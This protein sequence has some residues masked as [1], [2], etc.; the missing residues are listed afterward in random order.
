MRQALH[1]AAA[2]KHGDLSDY[3]IAHTKIA[4]VPVTM[5]RLMLLMD[6]SDWIRRKAIRLFQQ[7]PRLFARLLAIHTEAEPLSSVRAAELAGF[8]WK[9]LRT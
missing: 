6:R 4:A 3:Q 7:S 8:G 2:M 5:A 1:L 9:F